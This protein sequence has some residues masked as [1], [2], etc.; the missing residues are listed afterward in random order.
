MNSETGLTEYD[1]EDGFH[2]L[3]VHYTADPAKRSE[4]WKKR[5]QQG[6]TAADWEQ[7][8]EIN[9]NVPKGRPW[10]PEFRYDFH[11]AK[12]HIRPVPGRPVVRG[13]DYGLT[14][15]TVFC[16]TTAK[17]Q[18]L[19]L[20]PELQS[21]E[22]GV[23]AHGRVVV[24]ESATYL[25]GHQFIDYGDPAGNQRAQTDEKTCVQVLR[26]EFSIIV[27]S[28]PVSFAQRDTPIR[29]A[30]TTITADGQPMLLIDP[31]CTW[32]IAA[33]T[34]GYQRKE[35]GGRA[36]DVL[37]DNEYTHI[38]DALGYV[39]SMVGQASEPAK[40]KPI[41]GGGSMW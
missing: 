27:N 16:Q 4:E 19:V 36:T 32:L 30:L 29:K 26:E 35:V 31:R 7:E 9:F 33:L 34:G 5:E 18:T 25:P 1:T 13:W 41:P 8:M 23:L 10:Y 6:T 21:W 20:W 39:V 11:V 12:E 24:A 3:R 40:M 14:P 15:A 28:G 37:A 38:V 2:V 22:S 17:G